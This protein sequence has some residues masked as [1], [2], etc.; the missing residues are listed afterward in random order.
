[1]PPSPPGFTSLSAPKL[2]HNRQEFTRWFLVRFL[3]EALGAY[4]VG[5]QGN[6]AHGHSILSQAIGFVGADHARRAQGFDGVEAVEESVAASHA[7]TAAGEGEG[8]DVS[9]RVDVQVGDKGYPTRLAAVGRGVTIH[10]ENYPFDRPP[11]VESG[12]LCSFEHLLARRAQ[13]PRRLRRHVRP[14]R[15]VHE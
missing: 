9:P 11:A 1:M 4:V 5:I 10:L 12:G 6:E 8:R 14:A 2:R 7:Q 3:G 15:A 13:H